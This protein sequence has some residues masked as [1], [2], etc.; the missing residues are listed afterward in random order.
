MRESWSSRAIS[1]VV[2]GERVAG[3]RRLD[4]IAGEDLEVEPE[5]IA[6]LVLPL[7]DEAARGDDEAALDDRRGS[8]AP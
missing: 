1:A 8:S 5:L 4:L 2:L 3:A 7:L 6:E